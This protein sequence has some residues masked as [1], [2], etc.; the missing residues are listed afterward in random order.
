MGALSGRMALIQAEAD[1]I[2]R[3]PGTRGRVRSLH[4]SRDGKKIVTASS[5]DRIRVWTLAGGDPVTYDAPGANTLS[6]SPT[7]RASPPAA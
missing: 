4:I 6:F 5:G 3:A 7:G 2:S 1:G